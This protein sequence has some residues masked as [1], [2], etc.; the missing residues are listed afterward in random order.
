MSAK[1]INLISKY[2]PKNYKI[3]PKSIDVF[4]DE[5][6][7]NITTEK[8]RFL[9]ENLT[10]Q[11]EEIYFDMSDNNDILK[12][13]GIVKID[14]EYI[15]YNTKDMVNENLLN[16]ER[17]YLES[18]TTAH[19]NSVLWTAYL[20]SDIDEFTTTIPISGVSDNSL[21]P[22]NGKFIIFTDTNDIEEISY[23]SYNQWLNGNQF[24]SVT[25]G[26]GG[27]V[28]KKHPKGSRVT[29]YAT[30]IISQ[31]NTIRY[32]KGL[33]TVE[34]L[35]AVTEISSE[36]QI[37]NVFYGKLESPIVSTDNEINIYDI[38]GSIPKNGLIKIDN[39]IIKYGKFEISE[40]TPNT[41]T[42]KLL[43]RGYESSTSTSHLADTVIY[44][45]L[46]QNN[47]FIIDDEYVYYT[48]YDPISR[49]FKQLNRG[50]YSSTI[51]SHLI[52]TVITQ[53]KNLEFEKTG[54][55]KI[56]NEYF[57]YWNVDDEYFYYEDRPSISGKNYYYAQGG[58]ID[59]IVELHNQ[60]ATISTYYFDDDNSILIDFFHTIAEHLDIALIAKIDKFEDFSDVDN[61]DI[62]YLKHLV[63]LIGE[64][65]DDYQNLPYF[66]SV[67]YES[68]IRTFTKELTSI[69]KKQGL[70]TAL[71]VWHTI[72]SQPLE[73]YQNLWTFNYTSFYSLPFLCLIIYEGS[74]TYYPSENFF[75]PQ[76]SKELYKEIAYFYKDKKLYNKLISNLKLTIL[77]WNYFQKMD[78]DVISTNGGKVDD[79]LVPPDSLNN[80]D[81]YYDPTKVSLQERGTSNYYNL[82]FYVNDYNIDLFKFEDQ[83]DDE[84]DVFDDPDLSCF[85][86]ATDYGLKSDTDSDWIKDEDHSEI[87]DYCDPSDRLFPLKT[88]I[89]LLKDHNYDLGNAKLELVNNIEKTDTE[90][91]V[92]LISGKLYSPYSHISN[93]TNPKIKPKGYIKINDE[94]ISYS[95]LEFYDVHDGS[96]INKKYKLLDCERGVNRTTP[97]AYKV[98][99]YQDYEYLL[100]D[101]EIEEV[102][103]PHKITC[104]VDITTNILTHNDHGLETDDVIIF[105]KSNGAGIVINTYYLVSKIN[106]NEFQIRDIVT[107]VIIVITSNVQVV[108]QKIHFRLL[109]YRDPKNFNISIGDYIEIIQ[110]GY[111]EICEVVNIESE[112]DYCENSWVY[113]IDFTTTHP[114]NLNY[115]TL[116]YSEIYDCSID[117]DNSIIDSVDHGFING[118]KIYFLKGVGNLEPYINYYVI[119]SH[120]DYFRISNSNVTLTAVANPITDYFITATHHL[121]NE[122][123]YVIFSN[124]ICG[125][126]HSIL[127]RT[128]NVSA[129]QFQVLDSNGNIMNLT[130]GSNTF[131]SYINFDGIKDPINEFMECG[132]RVL[133]VVDSYQHRFS[134][135]Q[136]ILW[137]LENEIN[138]NDLELTYEMSTESLENNK[139]NSYKG[140]KNSIIWP[141]PH[142]NY[143]FEVT[144]TD[145]FPPDEVVQ[146]VLKK[147]KEYKPKNTV[148]DITLSYTLDGTEVGISPVNENFEVEILKS[149]A[150]VVGESPVSDYHI[151]LISDPVTGVVDFHYDIPVITTDDPVNYGQNVGFFYSVHKGTPQE[152][153]LYYGAFAAYPHDGI[154]KTDS[155]RRRKRFFSWLNS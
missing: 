56:D 107:G 31:V 26:N 99:L 125:V 132:T 110:S 139:L 82:P 93:G 74:R 33:F 72:I 131:I 17:G 118:D 153:L 114:P 44:H 7:D 8:Y 136:H 39:E 119:N 37:K 87:I 155:Y 2:L 98:N 51:T 66:S 148:P 50:F 88:D 62:D 144:G 16:L 55:I 46:P 120:P 27:T 86:I 12:S 100:Y 47:E 137:R 101:R 13:E 49:K 135:I 70:L 104:T 30:P 102:V 48:T 77:E 140:V 151:D 34:L 40:I 68:R 122:G 61:I 117:G 20:L 124:D 130:A 108:A 38:V 65:L 32:D 97:S 138:G 29:E 115:N 43:T 6:V 106:N 113:G 95:D 91:I 45:T 75:K 142:F 36:F 90:I 111:D 19:C 57:K 11:S 109:L 28:A 14:D 150:Y 60:G 71:K 1:F 96:F 4:L 58:V 127:Y 69:Y 80:L 22:K 129:H 25:R 76:M 92:K 147:I 42:L 149:D 154:T 63:K 79:K 21:I 59:G 126:L 84:K 78:D 67:N 143:G 15:K 112:Y 23:I 128:I 116:S 85:P 152:L 9:I 145:T 64:D 105:E 133:S 123:D 41:G 24:V 35:N 52:N 18:E 141:T 83:L 53:R 3:H 73:S 121:L 5:D 81:I 134:M 89:D 146:L 103:L 10:P 94:I 54:I